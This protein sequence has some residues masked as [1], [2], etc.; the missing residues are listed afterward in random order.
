MRLIDADKLIK[1]NIEDMHINTDFMTAAV[2]SAFNKILMNE[3]EIKAKPV[4]HGKWIV[5]VRRSLTREFKCSVCDESICF[6]YDTCFH[7][8][9]YCPFCGA[10]MDGGEE[11]E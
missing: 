3:P 11:S 5:N 1:K 7:E 8:Y 6:D 9:D 4:R 10:K 2:L